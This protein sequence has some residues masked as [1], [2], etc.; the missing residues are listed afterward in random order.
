MQAYDSVHIKAD[1]EMGGTDQLFNIL[2]GETLC[3][4]SVRRARLRF[5]CPFL[6]EQTVL[7]R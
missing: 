6:R 2:M 5:S 1:I 7:K 4:I 3:G